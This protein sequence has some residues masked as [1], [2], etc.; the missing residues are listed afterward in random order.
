MPC[1]RSLPRCARRCST[2]RSAAVRRGAW[3]R[4][5]E[6]VEGRGAAPFQVVAVLPHQVPESRRRRAALMRAMRRRSRSSTSSIAPSPATA[7][8]WSLIARAHMGHIHA[9]NPEQAVAFALVQFAQCAEK[10]L[11]AVVVLR[12]AALDQAMRERTAPGWAE[13]ARRGPARAA[14]KPPATPPCARRSGRN[15]PSPRRRRRVRPA[16]PP[17]AGR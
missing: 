1:R 4:F 3:G 9:Q 2:A 12:L 5:Q 14:G 11:D 17:G 13:C 15:L 10:A 8:N 6:S 16:S 7:V